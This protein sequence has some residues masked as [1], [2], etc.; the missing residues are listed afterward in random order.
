MK[1]LALL[2]VALMIVFSADAQKK[3][4]NEVYFRFGYSNPCW[5]QFGADKD[6]W[7]QWPGTT[8]RWGLTGEFGTIFMLTTL[9]R[10]ET[11][12]LGLDIDWVSFYW[13]RFTYEEMN[14][15][16]DMATMRFDTKVGPSLTFSPVKR[17]AI[18]VFVKADFGWF[19]GVALIENDDTGDAEGFGDI[20]AV[21]LSTGANF[22]FSILMVG[23]EFN[24]IT[25]KLENF[26][27]S[28]Y[29]LD[30]TDNDSDKSPL[31]SMNFTVGLSF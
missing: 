6:W 3:F 17:I 23:I 11:L 10:N 8:S 4:D 1:K 18:D 7:D 15:T 28:G 29:Y 2:I 26:D 30:F 13:H 27:E 31:P 19:T 21:G 22:R 24:T 25:T 12:A 9:N 5:T 20:F 16:L 14:Y